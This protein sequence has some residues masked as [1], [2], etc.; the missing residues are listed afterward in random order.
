MNAAFQ[1]YGIVYAAMA[2]VSVLV[3]VTL[4]ILSFTK[5]QG[6]GKAATTAGIA[7][8]LLTV[9]QVWSFA[10]SAIVG[11][12]AG[13]NAIQTYFALNSLFTSL[14]YV[15]TYWLFF[16]AIFLDRSPAV[17]PAGGHLSEGTPLADVVDDNPYAS[18][19]Q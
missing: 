2:L 7:F 15:F 19:R 9:L 5:K 18:P 17:S 13:V 8:M 14:V 10:F 4:M 12:L 1:W 11:R 6:Y 3:T 16:K